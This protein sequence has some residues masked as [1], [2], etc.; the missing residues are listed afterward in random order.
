[1]SNSHKIPAGTADHVSNSGSPVRVGDAVRMFGSTEL[2]KV[3]RL[4][5][6]L[7]GTLACCEIGNDRCRSYTRSVDLELETPVAD[8]VEGIVAASDRRLEVFELVQNEDHWKNPI[9]ATI[10]ADAATMDE[11]ADAVVFYT[12]SVPTFERVQG[13]GLRVRAAGYYRT[14][15]A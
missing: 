14:I 1:M 2:F 9:D 8:T 10:D 6:L 15:G 7:D 13:N 11:I 4:Y 5:W 12:G 3:L